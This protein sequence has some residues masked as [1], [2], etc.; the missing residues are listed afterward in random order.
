MSLREPQFHDDLVNFRLKRLASLGGAPAVR[1]CEGEFGLPRLEWRLLAAL[2]E[3]GS[4]RPTALARTQGVEQARASRAL[5]SLADKRLVSRQV[6]A[7][8]ARRATVA[9]TAAGVRLYRRLFPRLA[10]INVRLLDVLD[11]KELA[12]FE[13]CL[14]KLTRNAAGVLAAAGHG[15]PKAERRN[16]G[17]R[18]IWDRS[19][20]QNAA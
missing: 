7:L 9:A 2:V 18:R 5:T 15:G 13:A 11:D 20:H 3:H 1:L 4:N 8:D 10:Q 6:D 14:D 12:S 17:S 19:G 16:G